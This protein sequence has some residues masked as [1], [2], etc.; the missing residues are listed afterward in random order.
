L[1]EA[2][3]DER[4]YSLWVDNEFMVGPVFSQI[5]RAFSSGELPLR[6]EAI[7]GGFPLYNFTQATPFYPLYGFNFLGY[8]SHLETV[9]TLHRLTVVHVV[10]GVLAM[11]YMLRS[12]GLT[13]IAAA[14]GAVLY[15][16]SA[17]MASY[18]MWLNIVAPYAWLPLFVAGLIGI[19]SGSRPRLSVVLCVLSAAMIALASPSQPLIHAVLVASVLCVAY[20]ASAEGRTAPGRGSLAVARVG[21]AGLIAVLLCAPLLIPTVLDAPKMLRWIGDFPPILQSEKIPWDAFVAHKLPATQAAGILVSGERVSLV[22][23]PYVGFF[24]VPLVM[25]ALFL[26]RTWIVYAFCTLALYGLWSAF[27]DDLGLAYLNHEIPLLNKIREPSR[28]LVLFQFGSAALAAIGIESI[29]QASAA[30]GRERR[31]ALIALVMSCAVCLLVF[32][33]VALGNGA[34]RTDTG[35]VVGVVALHVISIYLLGRG[36]GQRFAPLLAS[37]WAA[38]VVINLVVAVSWTPPL[39]LSDSLYV[40]DDLAPLDAA[41]DFVARQPDGAERRVVFDGKFDKRHAAMLAAYRNLRSFD[42]YMITAPL[43]QAVAVSYEYSPYYLHYGAGYLICQKCDRSKYP[44]FE[45]MGQFGDYGVLRNSE[46]LGPHYVGHVVDEAADSA[47]FESKVKALGSMPD[48]PR[49]YVERNAV[50]DASSPSMARE[51]SPV[52]CTITALETRATRKTLSVG[53]SVGQLLVLNEF[54]DGN[55]V[56]SINGKRAETIVANGHQVAVILPAATQV[57]T[58]DYWPRSFVW[59]LAMVP[60]GALLLAV[61]LWRTRSTRV[62]PA[63]QGASN[64]GS[65]RFF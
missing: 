50:L 45:L 5:A 13:R 11:H 52:P 19:L 25:L 37:A 4:L 27:G 2:L 16:L 20:L 10:F 54:N 3:G 1:R 53:C 29:A 39:R 64:V 43:K 12:L 35:L 58:F 60:I 57:V 65:G 40:R 41:L 32:F 59:S 36:V 48:Y 6:M 51:P 17:D 7:L 18:K 22:G 61:F 34:T 38:G 9:Y 26:Q 44:G 55:W 46:G 28:N 30:D 49:I 56:A 31:L 14:A 33:V 21:F 24:I 63:P 42:Y 47:E 62:T 23:H 8:G 15:G